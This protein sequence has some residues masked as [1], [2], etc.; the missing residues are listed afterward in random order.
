MFTGVDVLTAFL[1]RG[2]PSLTE[3]ISELSGEL[4][5]EGRLSNA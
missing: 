3:R 2:V 5:N 4:E 1:E